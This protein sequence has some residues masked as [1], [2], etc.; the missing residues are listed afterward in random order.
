MI[1]RI[2]KIVEE[3]AQPI[4]GTEMPENLDIAAA[5]DD[6]AQFESGDELMTS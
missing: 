3:E 4:R 1:Y 2:A 5:Y 6:W